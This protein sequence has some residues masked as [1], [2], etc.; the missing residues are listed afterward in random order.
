VA[1]AIREFDDTFTMFN[2]A[3]KPAKD[4]LGNEAAM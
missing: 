1:P 3:L 2:N 4:L